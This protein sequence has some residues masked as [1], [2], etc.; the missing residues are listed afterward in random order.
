MSQ[1]ILEHYKAQLLDR[2][3]DVIVITDNN[4]EGPSGP[5][6]QYVNKAF[7]N[8]TGYTAEEVLGQTPRMLQGPKTDKAVLKKIKEALTAG[9]SIEVEL[10][11]YG[12]NNQEYWL[13]FSVTPLYDDNNKL[14]YFAAIERDITHH[15]QLTHALSE[16]AHK[17]SLTE[18]LNRY[19]FYKISREMLTKYH[20][21]HVKFALMV[22]DIDDFK[23][24]NDEFG[25][26]EG[27]THI[28]LLPKF[29]QEVFRKDDAICRF[30]GDE[31]IV[32]IHDVD[33]D[34]LEKKQKCYKKS[35]SEQKISKQQ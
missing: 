26:L 21:D 22:L 18:V 30:G 15:K 24:I 25:H 20:K 19:S 5:A 11:N 16:M 32:L 2:T 33:E 31:F 34:T 10:L 8:L 17:D 4:L 13:E 14:V 7:E 29:C 28:R 9:K 6:I 12:K 23:K 35:F 3:N 27:D 1:E